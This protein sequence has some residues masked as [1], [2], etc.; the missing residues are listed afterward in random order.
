MPSYRC[1]TC[2]AQFQGG[3]ATQFDGIDCFPRCPN[4]PA[5]FSPETWHT[6]APMD[7]PGPAP[8]TTVDAVSDTGANTAAAVMAPPKRM[9]FAELAAR[10]SQSNVNA[11]VVVK[12]AFGTD[13]KVRGASIVSK[14]LTL[15]NLRGGTIKA[16]THEYEYE[17]SG[18]WTHAEVR[19]ACALWRAQPAVG[20]LHNF[21]IPGY[22]TSNAATWTGSRKATGLDVRKGDVQTNLICVET[23][24][25][26][27][28]KHNVHV[29][30]R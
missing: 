14:T 12:P 23:A 3:Q 9:S 19:E 15:V 20:A 7:D 8:A 21:H 11:P 10:A 24:N 27:D 4:A 16:A 22:N 28:W 17:L 26:T 13:P 29:S 30:H 18:W 1:L 25:G 5:F 6:V 2:Y